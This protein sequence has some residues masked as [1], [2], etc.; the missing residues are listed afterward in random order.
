M[1]N[2]LL[3]DNKNYK[4]LWLNNFKLDNNDEL[5]GSL[6]PK[7]YFNDKVYVVLRNNMESNLFESSNSKWTNKNF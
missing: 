3:L 4:S 2:V 5:I 1:N 6:N 7:Y